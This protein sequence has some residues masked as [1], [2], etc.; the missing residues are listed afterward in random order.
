MQRITLKEKYQHL[1]LY[2]EEEQNEN[3][4]ETGIPKVPFAQWTY[5]Y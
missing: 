4:L 3:Q 2:S 5:Q 1:P